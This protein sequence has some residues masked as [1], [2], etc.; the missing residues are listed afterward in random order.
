METVLPGSKKIKELMTSPGP[1][2]LLAEHVSL[3]ENIREYQNEKHYSDIFWYQNFGNDFH[4]K[5]I[6][7]KLDEMFKSKHTIFLTTMNP[8]V[9]DCFHFENEK[10]VQ[11][12][13]LFMKDKYINVLSDEEANYFFQA[14]KTGIQYVSEILKTQGYW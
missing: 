5:I 14:Y 2:V 3:F 6:E 8:Y 13:L 7:S 9:I 12:R 1:H 11:S 10:E 4:Y